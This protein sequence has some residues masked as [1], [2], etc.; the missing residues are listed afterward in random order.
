M[1]QRNLMIVKFVIYI[2]IISP[3]VSTSIKR[4]P[5]Y[6]KGNAINSVYG[7]LHS[8]LKKII[9][10]YLFAYT[11]INYTNREQNKHRWQDN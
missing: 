9:Y 5:N 3:T 4:D 6:V 8:V 1:E 7:I 10:V 2:E 11:L